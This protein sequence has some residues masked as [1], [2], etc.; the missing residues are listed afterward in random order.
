MDRAL[1]YI[2]IARK[3]GKLAVGE[4]N[5]GNAV[6][7]D[8]APLLLL[9]QDASANARSRAEGFIYGTGTLLV[10]LPYTNLHMAQLMG[11]AGFSMAAVTDLGLALGVMRAL[12]ED[13]PGKFTEALEALS[14]RLRRSEQRKSEEKAHQKNLKQG[15]RR[16]V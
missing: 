7:R 13:A 10:D 8:H 15:K 4:E 1:N 14:D 9:A 11:K 16:K 2:G 12:E 5:A 6:R 3:A